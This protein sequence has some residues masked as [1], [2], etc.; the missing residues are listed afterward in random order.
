MGPQTSVTKYNGDTEWGTITKEI[1]RG[2]STSR[3]T[4]NSST[5]FLWESFCNS[6]CVDPYLQKCIDKLPPLL[7]FAHRYRHGV[8]S[9]SGNHVRVR[10]VG[11]AVRAVGQKMA[12]LGLPD[13]R[14]TPL[15]KL[16][17]RLSR[18]LASYTKTDPLPS[19]VKPIPVPILCHSVTMAR[20]GN[21]PASTAVA[22][23]IILA[24]YFLL[25]PG[26][27]IFTSNADAAP[28]CLC[29]LHFIV[30]NRRLGHFRCTDQELE[31][32][33]FVGLEFTTQKNGVK[34]EI[35]GLGHSGDPSFCPVTSLIS[36]IQ[37]LRS[38][39]ASPDTPIYSYFEHNKWKLLSSSILSATLRHAVTTIGAQYGIAPADVST[40][41][42]RASGS[43]ALL[44]AKVDTSHNRLFGRWRSDKMF[45]YL[46]VQAFP[47]IHPLASSMLQHGTYAMLPN[48]Q[49]L[50]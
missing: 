23:L 48:H 40:R 12:Q 31:S 26:K 46:H 47:L 8:L 4:A 7:I 18:L 33:T 9:P 41:S 20:L 11:D 22:D 36:H 50:D 35:L 10:M 1:T 45:R 49:L 15:G 17:F 32:A 21:T 28:F 44:C 30:V 37:H 34:G 42:L 24:F 27:Y 39:H 13:P 14:L 2:I 43:M 38:Y 19:R 25:R 3:A 29:N 5:W 6:I 16:E